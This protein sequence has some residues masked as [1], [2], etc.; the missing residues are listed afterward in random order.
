[1]DKP[2]LRVV[3][4]S[5]SG[6]YVVLRRR[7]GALIVCRAER[8]VDA[9]PATEVLVLDGTVDQPG[10]ARLQWADLSPLCVEVLEIGCPDDRAAQ[11]LDR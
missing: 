5:V 9:P 10:H 4:T 11:L 3:G 2:V 7:G 8:A 6:T 1:M